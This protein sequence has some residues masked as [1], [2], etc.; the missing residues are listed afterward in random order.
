VD[1]NSTS[2]LVPVWILQMKQIRAA[3][4][5]VVL[6]VSVLLLSCSQLEYQTADPVPDHDGQYDT[7][8]PQTAV[9]YDLERLV[10][11]TKMIFAQ[12]HY[13]THF[14]TV[15]DQVRERD[16][17]KETLK[18]AYDSQYIQK[19]VS[20]TATVI[21]N[22]TRHIALLSCA[23]IFAKPDT[24]ITFHR[25]A[26]KNK[27]DFIESIS[28]K[29]K[30]SNFAR[31]VPGIGDLEILI[32]DKDRDIAL[33]G[34]KKPASF[35]PGLL[36]RLT[37]P[38]GN[39][40]ELRW[41]TFV[42]VIGYPSGYQIITKG[43]VSRYERDRE[44]IFLIDAPFNPGFS[45]GLVVALRDGVPNFE[46]VGI[47]TS[48]AGEDEAFLVPTKHRDY[49]E[50]VPYADSVF[51]EYKTNIKYGITFATT[52]NAV[53]ALIRKNMPLLRRM[54]YDFSAMIK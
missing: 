13:K 17:N 11:A 38:F 54:G 18:E 40:K 12:A 43:I 44:N 28:I 2:I 9:S 46:A 47:V 14:Y 22:D 29:Q 42:Y 4:K 20:G 24:I 19:S 21:L 35:R 36:P 37:Y 39:A 23:H 6:T 32:M 25:D 31:D 48:A 33:L 7:E 34:T 16:I 27:S 53:V 15:Q 41:G 49:V 30:Q 26:N 5:S 3:L 51:V 10:H 52:T 45:G 8:F 1:E 50:N